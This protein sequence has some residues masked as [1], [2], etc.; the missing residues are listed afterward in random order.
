LQ[1]EHNLLQETEFKN[2]HCPQSPY[3]FPWSFSNSKVL[4]FWFLLIISKNVIFQAN[5]LWIF[6]L[7]FHF[8]LSNSF[9]STFFP[10]FPHRSWHPSGKKNWFKRKKRKYYYIRAN[11]LL[12]SIAEEG[13]ILELTDCQVLVLKLC[14]TCKI[15]KN[16]RTHHCRICDV[17]IDVLDHHCDWVGNCIGKTNRRLFLCFLISSIFL[18]FLMV[19]HGIWEIDVLINERQGFYNKTYI[20]FPI[21]IMLLSGYISSCLIYLL[22]FHIL[23]IK[24]G[25][26]TIEYIKGKFKEEKNP[27]HKGFWKN[28]YNIFCFNKEN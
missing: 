1:K 14:E 16:S 15:Y 25:M 17:C 12:K 22:S 7:N 23:L 18:T 28:L 13:K 8:G 10:L 20:F 19:A 27:Y 26:T 24:K 3:N 4:I 5:F 2:G 6:L 9:L 21:I 11:F